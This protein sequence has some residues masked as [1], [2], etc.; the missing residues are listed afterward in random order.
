[1][2]RSVCAAALIL[3]MTSYVLFMEFGNE[4][5]AID[6]ARGGIFEK[7]DQQCLR[8]LRKTKER[9]IWRLAWFCSFMSTVVLTALYCLSPGFEHLDVC[10]FSL[11]SFVVSY[12]SS[13]SVLSYYTWHIVCPNYDCSNSRSC[14]NVMSEGDLPP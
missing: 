1:M 4:P 11:L 5:R 7:V 14:E 12:F 10:S 9:P 13:Y 6:A 2:Y 3:C 8:Y